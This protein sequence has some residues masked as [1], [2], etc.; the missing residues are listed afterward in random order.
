MR[1]ATTLVMI[2]IGVIVIGTLTFGALGY[3]NKQ[4]IKSKVISKER[5]LEPNKQGVHSYYLIF[6]EAGPLKLEDDLIYGNFNS[7]DWYGQIITDSTYTFHTV[8][9]RI[10]YL[11]AYPNIVSFEK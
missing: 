7:S 3:G 5:I 6:T 2:F 8:G 9:Y 11:N 10:G 4:V 1:T